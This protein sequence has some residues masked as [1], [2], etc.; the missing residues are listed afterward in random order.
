MDKEKS[1]SP[2]FLERKEENAGDAL[3]NIER[4]LCPIDPSHSIYRYNIEKHMK[5]CNIRKREDKIKTLGVYCQDCNSGPNVTTLDPS[6]SSSLSSSSP[7]NS[8]QL[9][10]VDVEA[11]VRKIQ[12]CYEGSVVSN[13]TE[14][15]PNEGPLFPGVRQDILRIVGGSQTAFEKIK[16][17]KQDAALV[18]IMI[19]SG[20]L[21]VDQRGEDM[22]M[23]RRSED[24]DTTS[25]NK[26]CD[27][28][29]QNG[30]IRGLDNDVICEFGA[31][32]G[33]LGLAISCVQPRSEIKFIE[34]IGLRRKADKNMKSLGRRFE[35]IR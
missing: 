19:D 27:N 14:E 34:R 24:K 9:A 12:S 25:F 7:S 13:I 10:L 6:P 4:I 21:Q 35:R 31:G 11:L 33:L 3:A 22:I 18:N 8:A 28:V 30:Q 17:A 15:I 2:S 26:D 20:L 32:K 1:G 16:H 29:H 5:I 23:T